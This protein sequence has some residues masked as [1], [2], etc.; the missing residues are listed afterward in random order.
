MAKQQTEPSPS[1][2]KRFLVGLGLPTGLIA[3]AMAI[4]F[5][6]PPELQDQISH[7]V[8][9]QDSTT[10]IQPP[11]PTVELPVT[12]LTDFY[13]TSTTSDIVSHDFIKL[14][15]VE[16]HEQAEWVAYE[17]RAENLQ[18]FPFQRPS[19]FR[20]DPKVPEGS[21]HPSDYLNSG[22]DRGHL[23]PAAD[24]SFD[25]DALKQSFY[26]SNI[27]PQQPGFNRGIWKEL[28]MQVR[29]WCK[30]S[31]KLYIVTGPVLTLRAQ[32]RL[33]KD[34]ALAAPARYYKILL[35]LNETSAKAAAFLL[36]NKKSDERLSDYMVTIDS[37]EALTQI[38]FF[39]QLPDEQERALESQTFV[40]SW[41]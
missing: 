40:N 2:L 35:D 12:Y 3:V 33:G 8:D 29:D 36:P 28:E 1:R 4:F 13:P 7:W 39:P 18:T 17:L 14:S 6:L 23:A 20:V 27:S 24:M 30:Q 22:Y 25:E 41:S 31:Q 11:I 16:S 34:K 5:A 32:R 9:E 15:Y 10:I 19:S 38:D 37:L 26:M 21:A